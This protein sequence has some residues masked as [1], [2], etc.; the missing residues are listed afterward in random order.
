MQA[1][2]RGWVGLQARAHTKSNRSRR[3]VLGA[4][5][6]LALAAVA[7]GGVQ[8]VGVYAAG[9]VWQGALSPWLG[10]CVL[11]VCVCVCVCAGGRGNV[12]AGV[13][14]Y[15]QTHTHTHLSLIHI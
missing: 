14:A 1:L 9:W 3:W 4:A 13:C 6:V 2:R 8:R 7:C 12:C 10:V 5:A 15:L 11:C